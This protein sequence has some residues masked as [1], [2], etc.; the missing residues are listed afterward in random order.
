M[1]VFV[2]NVGNRDVVLNIG[3]S[4]SP[5]YV[6]LDKG[7]EGLA[8]GKFLNCPGEGTRALAKYIRERLTE[9][10]WRLLFPIL[11]PA[12]AEA[13]GVEGTLDMVL[14]LASDQPEGAGPHRLWDTIESAG[15]LQDCLP[16]R[17][18]ERISRPTVVRAEFNPSLHD[19]AFTFVGEV[20]QRLVPPVRVNHVFASVKGG[21]PAM[22]AA[23]RQQTV[24][25]YG[26]KVSIIEVEEPPSREDRLAGR[27]GAARIPST[28]PFRRGTILR[29]AATLLSRYDYEG[30]R[31]LL[32]AE[33][34]KDG[35]IEA[36]LRHAHSRL[37]LDFDDAVENL[38]RFG[39]GR[40]HQWRI[41]AGAAWSRQ[42]L[43]DV[44]KSAAVCLARL[45]FIGFL[46]RVATFCENCR[47]QL[48]YMATGLRIEAC[49]F[50]SSIRDE[51]LLADLRARKR[52][53]VLKTS[54]DREP[55]WK[56]DRALFNAIL[57]YW[58]TRRAVGSDAGRRIQ[59]IHEE[60][61]RLRKLEDLRHAVLHQMKGVSRTDIEAKLPDPMR[62][63]SEITTSILDAIESVERIVG[64]TSHVVKTIYD[65][66]NGE[67]LDRLEAYSP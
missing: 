9:L 62:A 42:R 66:I 25:L 11:S 67:V 59:A 3:T 15:I 33:G 61:S 8:A 14:L 22:N 27:T 53:S 1:R 35:E 48:V 34:V 57:D 39:A 20:L 65:E 16:R 58:V 30:L 32:E 49:L 46:A 36:L 51:N 41:S 63:F 4:E 64:T 45:D 26:P 55:P 37:N 18:P 7:E 44:Q 43:L 19:E 17:F 29:L 40:P 21:I 50:P 10:E 54:G 23:L 13:L 24:A 2:G 47:R 52:L 60:L 6:S 38:R 5:F 31:V 28:W 56:A 12:L